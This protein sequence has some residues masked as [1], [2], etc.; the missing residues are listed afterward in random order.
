M[1]IG[2]SKGL[3]KE[4]EVLKQNRSITHR[5]TELEFEVKRVGKEEAESLRSVNVADNTRPNS[6]H[7]CFQNE[8]RRLGGVTTEHVRTIYMK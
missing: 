2:T 8:P 6:F 4:Y 5:R 1:V 3:S 7:P